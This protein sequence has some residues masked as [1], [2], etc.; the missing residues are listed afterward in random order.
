MVQGGGLDANLNEKP[1]YGRVPLEANNGLRNDRGTLAAARMVDPNSAT[2]QFFINLQNNANLN[3]PKPDGYGYAVFG[4]VVRGMDVVD[5]MANVST[6]TVRGFSN[7][8]TTP[9]TI[10]SVAID[11]SPVQSAAAPA[12]GSDPSGQSKKGGKQANLAAEPAAAGAPGTPLNADME[13]RLSMAQGRGAKSKQ[14]TGPLCYAELRRKALGDKANT[15][16]PLPEV[17][18]RWY[19]ETMASY[20]NSSAAEAESIANVVQV[21]EGDEL[22][23]CMKRAWLARRD[24]LMKGAVRVAIAQPSAPATSQAGQA[25]SGLA[26][27]GLI[28]ESELKDIYTGPNAGVNRKDPESAARYIRSVA[29]DYHSAGLAKT[30]ETIEM[31][32]GYA[33]KR[34]ADSC[35]LREYQARKRELMKVAGQGAKPGQQTVTGASGISQSPEKKDAPLLCQSE[36]YDTYLGPNAGVNRKTPEIAA[37]IM[38]QISNDVANATLE[39]VDEQILP[40]QHRADPL[41]RCIFGAYKTRRAELLK[42]AAA[43]SSQPA[44]KGGKAGAVRYVT[45][46]RECVRQG[47]DGDRVTYTNVCAERIQIGYCHVTAA[48]AEDHTVC[49]PSPSEYS[50]SGQTYVTQSAGL[51]PGAT[52]TQA[53]AYKGIQRTYLVACKDSFP[54][55]DGFPGGRIAGEAR[56]ACWT[57]K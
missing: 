24:A 51:E 16:T 31:L 13:R 33:N 34:P 20:A 37:N 52:H 6:S 54:I 44:S 49:K 3:A 42:I 57:M 7:V 30:E 12:A 19:E 8:P 45:P 25:Q 18:Q 50:K 22:G 26:R 21:Q 29:D 17:E 5:S 38:H 27:G 23:A 41:L 2:N 10:L 43:Q 39:S 9:I 4:K 11:T 15:D 53:W 55:I 1:T 56:M 14:G 32:S 48:S 47:S 28:C 40:Y 46:H 35:L 36:A